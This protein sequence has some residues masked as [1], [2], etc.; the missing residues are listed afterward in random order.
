[1]AAEAGS[2]HAASFRDPDILPIFSLDYQARKSRV[3]QGTA[4]TTFVTFFIYLKF[5][6]V[7]LGRHHAPH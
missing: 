4:T 7:R 1:M 6:S 2:D 5:F 3:I